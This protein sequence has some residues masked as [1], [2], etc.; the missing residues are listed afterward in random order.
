[1]VEK[2][3]PHEGHRERMKQRYLSQGLDGFA[4]HEVLE[5]LLFYSVP[6]ADTNELAHA[7]LD[8]FSDLHGV[9]SAE[10]RELCQVSGVKM[11]TAILFRLV[12]DVYRRSCLEKTKKQVSYRSMKAV[13]AYLRDL[14]I[15]VRNERVY[16][17]LF[18]NGMNLQDTV[19]LAEGAVNSTAITYQTVAEQ[20]LFHRSSGVILAHN[21]PGGIPVPSGSDLEVT[22]NVDNVLS[23][24]GVRLIEHVVIADHSY[25]LI[26]HGRSAGHKA[27]AP[28][29]FSASTCGAE[30]D[31]AASLPE[32]FFD[33]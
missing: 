25:E 32:D 29:S 22:R 9:L 5:M 27:S 4:E 26:I 33:C 6:R 23:A 12:S 30:P 14:F 16:M 17:L 21:H 7:L 8:R 15:G 31:L 19:L 24:V 28:L 20:A 10:P 11:H 13:I 18:D 2:K 3:N 1:M